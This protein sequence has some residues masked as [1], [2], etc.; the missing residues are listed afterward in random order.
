MRAP[1]KGCTERTAV[2]NCHMTCEQY[3]KWKAEDSIAKKKQHD[4][5]T[6]FWKRFGKPI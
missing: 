3:L 4:T 6:L 2:P 1:C 5:S